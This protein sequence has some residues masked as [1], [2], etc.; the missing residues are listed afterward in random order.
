MDT[1][2]TGLVIDHSIGFNLT[3]IKNSKDC[4]AGHV[5]YTSSNWL[6]LGYWCNNTEVNIGGVTATA[7]AL[8]KTQE[9]CCPNFAKQGGEENACLDPGN[10]CVCNKNCSKSKRDSLPATKLP[11][12]YMGIGFAR[13]NL[14]WYNLF[15][16]VNAIDGVPVDSTTHRQGYVINS[17]GVWLGLT[18]ANTEG[19]N[20]VKLD[21]R[22]SKGGPVSRDWAEPPCAVQINDGVW[23]AGTILADTGINNSYV[24]GNTSHLMPKDKITIAI[25]DSSSALGEVQFD[26]VPYSERKTIHTENPVQP[27]W[28]GNRSVYGVN[29]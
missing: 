25:T 18:G 28:V 14:P 24:K 19:F 29:T 16:N 27:T 11:T 22:S 3:E 6:Q 8:I 1:G 20:A 17:T 12:A 15:L 26:F 4:W 13:G 21:L 2:S 5:F 7:A 9:I 23:Q 10:V